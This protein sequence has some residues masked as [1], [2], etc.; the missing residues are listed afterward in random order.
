M[1]TLTII[2][3]LPG[4]GKSTLARKLSAETGAIHIEPD[5]FCM[6]DGEY[7]Y[8]PE[9][10][11][12]AY[13]TARSIII[14][15]ANEMKCD[16]IFADVLP[17]I[18]QVDS[19]RYL[20]PS[21]YKL[22][23]R[24]LKISK[25]ESLKRNKHNVK[26]EDIENMAEAWQSWRRGETVTECSRLPKLTAE[27]FDRPDCP[28][29]AKYAAVDA[30][31]TVWAY[32]NEPWPNKEYGCWICHTYS[33][34]GEVYIAEGFDPS[35]WQNSLIKRPEETTLPDWCEVGEWIYTSS[36]QYLK[37][38]GISIDL[39]KIKFSN[40]AVWSNQDII[41]EA[42]QARLRPYTA[43]E[44]QGLVGK[45]L[46]GNDFDFSALI[47]YAEPNASTI[48]TLHYSYTAEELKQNYTIDGH[49]AGVL[50]HL[51][52]GEWVQ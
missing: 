49:P 9:K 24:D 22:V 8:D 7:K 17:R 27:V 39:Q 1:P 41:D 36:E 38:N 23:V 37:I 4:S 35:D 5:M 47:L 12:M 29:W 19:F 50:E 48:E 21:N 40:G 11:N 30:D 6:Q 44:M 51:E 16:I 26:P 10:Y 14:L 32:D 18:G 34:E 46:H 15:L 42:V 3:G 33:D 13:H 2:R 43:D 45:V 31:G 52:N 28:E 25:E 20:I